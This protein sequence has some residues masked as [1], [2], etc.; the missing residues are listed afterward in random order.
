M[1][2]YYGIFLLIIII[3][4]S[5]LGSYIKKREGLTNNENT[6]N[7]FIDKIKSEINKTTNDESKLIA[8]KDALD[9]SNY[10]KNMI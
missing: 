10:I 7:L 4:L 8:L 5:V 2:E 1:K 6:L 3:I 9:Y